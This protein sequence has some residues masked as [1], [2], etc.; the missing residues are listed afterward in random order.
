MCTSITSSQTSSLTYPSHLPLSFNFSCLHPTSY[1]IERFTTTNQITFHPS[2]HRFNAILTFPIHTVFVS[3][4][5]SKTWTFISIRHDHPLNRSVTIL[6]HLLREATEY[7]A[8]EGSDSL[9]QTWITETPLNP[10]WEDSEQRGFY[11]HIYIATNIQQWMHE[12]MTYLYFNQPCSAAV[13]VAKR[14]STRDLQ[15]MHP[16]FL[17]LL[18][19]YDRTITADAQ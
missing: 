9:R 10:G 11:Y 18:Q 2:Y 1:P 12:N 6:G 14:L 5:T 13:G 15:F 4:T 8:A 7:G 19:Y 17:Q 3:H 16:R